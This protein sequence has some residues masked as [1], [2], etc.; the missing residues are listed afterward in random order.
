MIQLVKS[1]QL[2]WIFTEKS[3]CIF[4][5]NSCICSFLP[6]ISMSS[7]YMMIMHIPS[8]FSVNSI[9]GSAGL[10]VKPKGSFF[11]SSK[12]ALLLDINHICLLVVGSCIQLEKSYQ[13]NQSHC[14]ITCCVSLIIVYCL[15]AVSTCL[16]CPEHQSLHFEFV[17][18]L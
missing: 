4:V 14:S 1:Y 8:S 9:H 12:I 18:L 17:M 15:I 13:I 7:T 2:C 10:N 5:A 11:I 6:I 3:F 16:C